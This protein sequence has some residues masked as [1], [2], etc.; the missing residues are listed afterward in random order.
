MKLCSTFPFWKLSDLSKWGFHSTAA[1]PS[2]SVH[3]HTGI[4]WS[5]SVFNTPFP[6]P[7]H[8]T[9]CCSSCAWPWCLQGSPLGPAVGTGKSWD[10]AKLAQNQQVRGFFIK[11][12]LL[13]S[14][15]FLNEDLVFG[16]YWK[17]CYGFVPF[18]TNSLHCNTCWKRDWR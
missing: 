5:C 17:N 15:G 13:L 16:T 9:L 3:V 11:T 10:T 14:A 18:P 2:V 12:A 7:S 1:V 4:L 8:P 6:P